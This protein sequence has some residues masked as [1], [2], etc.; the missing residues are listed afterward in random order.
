L[1]KRVRSLGLSDQ[2]AIN[3]M[4][5][6]NHESSRRENWG[7]PDWW[8]TETSSY[9]FRD[10]DPNNIREELMELA[11]KGDIGAME[12]FQFYQ[13]ATADQIQKLK[14]LI[15]KRQTARA[16]DL[17]ASV[18]GV[19]PT[20]AP[21]NEMAHKT[22]ST[23]DK[24][25]KVSKS[26]LSYI[27]R[28]GQLTAR[29]GYDLTP[30]AGYLIDKFEDLKDEIKRSDPGQWAKFCSDRGWSSDCEAIDFFA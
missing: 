10:T 16:W 29:G 18:V 3:L 12:M 8:D 17:V 27:E 6:M 21:V 25:D 19:R 14:R 2:E 28:G 15:N 22:K 9:P 26:L 5:R 1:L 4:Q 23:L 7:D 11:Y 24:L 13:Q 30:R 20:S